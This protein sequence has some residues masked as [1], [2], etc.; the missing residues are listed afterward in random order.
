MGDPEG[1]SRSNTW[2]KWLLN[3]HRSRLTAGA[4]LGAL[5]SRSSLKLHKLT[6][7]ANSVAQL[8]TSVKLR[9]VP[10]ISYASIL[11]KSANTTLEARETCGYSVWVSVW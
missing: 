3:N 11:A 10:N 6:C 5:D 4:L 1:E 2:N 9:Q 7:L 8:E